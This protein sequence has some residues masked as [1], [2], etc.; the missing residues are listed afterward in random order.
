MRRSRTRAQR[1][2][3]LVGLAYLAPAVLFVA[4]FTAYPFVQ[5]F[6]VSLTNW[7]LL[8]PP[9]FV[10]LANF[11]RAWNDGQF[12]TS[13][14]FTLKYTVWI[15]PI[16]MIGGYLIAL[17]TV[18]NTPVRRFA[19]TVVFV[20]VVIGFGASSLMWY[21]LFS[22]RGGLVNRMLG[23]LGIIDQPVLWLGVDPTTSMWAVIVSVVWKFMGFGMLLFVVAIQAIPSEINESAMVDG[24]SYV[25]RVLRVTLPLTAPTVLF[26]T[27]ISVIGS[28]LAF[29]Q[30]FI[31]TA[32]QPLNETATS[33]FYV[34]L[35]SFP[36]LR[37]GYGAALSLILAAVVLTFTVVQIALTH[38]SRVRWG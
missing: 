36:F 15:T 38:R 30:F 4:T 33:V 8:A 20:P 32:G 25:Q 29:D 1:R 5:M 31:M 35:N 22:P 37:L 6:W 23:D 11:R 2:R 12:W 13:L 7:S 28:L 27:L 14:S 17:L 24:A 18:R 26:V 9:E 19:R 21:W 10:G 34:Y 3:V 16:L